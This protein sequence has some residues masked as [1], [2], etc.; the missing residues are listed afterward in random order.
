M[1]TQSR[2][3]RLPLCLFQLDRQVPSFLLYDV[4]ALSKLFESFDEN[5][6][7]SVKV[8][9]IKN[10]VRLVSDVAGRRSR[11]ETVR[12]GIVWYGIA[13]YGMVLHGWYGMVWYGMVWYGMVWY[14]VAA[15]VYTKNLL[16]MFSKAVCFLDTTAFFVSTILVPVTLQKSHNINAPGGWV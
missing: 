7:S 15:R 5:K 12:Y 9:K 16:E 13:W 11:E 6:D 3:N 10:W 1:E 14:A 2:C 4:Y 8:I